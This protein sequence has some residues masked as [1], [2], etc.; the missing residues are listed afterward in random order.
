MPSPALL[1]APPEEQ[2]LWQNGRPLLP[3]RLFDRRDRAGAKPSTPTATA[4]P[5]TMQGLRRRLFA[6]PRGPSARRDGKQRFKRIADLSVKKPEWSRVQAVLLR[7][8][9]QRKRSRTGRRRRAIC[10]SRKVVSKCCARRK[11]DFSAY[12]VARYAL[13]RRAIVPGPRRRTRIYDRV[14]AE[15]GIHRMSQTRPRPPVQ[16]L[17]MVP[18]RPRSRY[19]NACEGAGLRKGHAIPIG[20]YASNLAF[21][22]SLRLRRG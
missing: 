1:H 6:V 12:L 5:L 11:P 9:A 21:H 7:E 13:R 22:F 2:A 19:R 18:P 3:F 20:P 14:D 8:T 16:R 4:L 17:P 10:P 15:G